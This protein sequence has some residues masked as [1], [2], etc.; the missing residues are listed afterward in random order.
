VFILHTKISIQNK[1]WR[2]VINSFD[3][4]FFDDPS[5]E[6]FVEHFGKSASSE[7]IIFLGSESS[8][9]HKDLDNLLN[10]F[11]YLMY[12]AIVPH[13]IYQD[14]SYSKGALVAKASKESRFL[15]MEQTYPNAMMQDNYSLILKN[16]ENR[17]LNQL[18]IFLDPFT[19]NVENNLNF[20][21]DIFGAEISYFGGG[22]GYLDL[23]HRPCIITPLGVQKGVTLLIFTKESNKLLSRHGYKPTSDIIFCHTENENTISELDFQPAFEQY[24][25]QV[26]SH[27]SK[28]ITREDFHFMAPLYPFGIKDIDGNFVLR[29]PV[30]LNGDNIELI[31][32]VQNNSIVY[33]MHSNKDEL[34]KSITQLAKNIKPQAES[35]FMID[36]IS[37]L[38]I[39]KND[40][41]EEIKTI[42]TKSKKNFGILSIGEI[43]CR[44]TFLSFLN[45]TCAVSIKE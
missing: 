9:T 44:N 19:K 5:I 29:D 10:S 38:F 17:G 13:V 23:E 30:K 43:C 4:K 8:I 42:S 14:K 34:S 22:A 41:S 36:C 33:L 39:L 25:K 18:N 1:F 6:E 32:E 12:G 26:Y 31:A 21:F 20:L 3:F 15:I 28:W 24:K 45:K 35:T 37:R 40:F 27:C 16:M 2:S 11:D 7:Y